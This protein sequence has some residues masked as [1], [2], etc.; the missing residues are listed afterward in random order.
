LFPDARVSVLYSEKAPA[1]LKSEIQALPDEKV[2]RFQ[3]STDEGL[4]YALRDAFADSDVLLGV[5][6][7]GVYSPATIKN[8]L[9][10]AYRQNIPLI[11]PHQAYIRAGAIATTYSSVADTARRLT[12]LLQVPLLS[13]P[14]SNPYFSVL[15]NEQVARSLNIRLPDNTPALLKRISD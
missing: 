7:N 6:D 11:G 8:I 14:A 13:P 9:I 12:E 15:F 2:A 4:N 3:M 5:A 10:S 1:W